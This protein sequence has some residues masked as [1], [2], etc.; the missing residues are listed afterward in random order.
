MERFEYRKTLGTVA[1]GAR[2]VW[3]IPP[4][5]PR[6]QALKSEDANASQRLWGTLGIPPEMDHPYTC[7]LF[8]LVCVLGVWKS[9]M[10]NAIRLRWPPTKK[11]RIYFPDTHVCEANG[12]YTPLPPH[13]VL[14]VADH[15]SQ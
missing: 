7:R 15:R 6:A 4:V 12:L 13:I 2:I 1:G 10:L 9:P 8:R 5:P 11:P 3:W 14:P